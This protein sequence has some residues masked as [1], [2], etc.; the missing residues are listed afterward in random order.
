MNYLIDTHIL[1]WSLIE[2]NKINEK[3]QN[4][5]KDKKNT[6]F[7]SKISFWEISLKYSLGKIEL[8]GIQPED[9]EKGTIKLGF[10]IKDIETNEVLSYYNL[11]KFKDHKDPFDRM[12]IWQCIKNKYILISR[13]SRIEN[14]KNL[15]L[16][17]IS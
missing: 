9:F 13:D 15:G 12:I 7:V 16:K 10:E 1:I 14:Y 6:I 3:L 2:P 4:I 5:L 8:T 17:S 11:P